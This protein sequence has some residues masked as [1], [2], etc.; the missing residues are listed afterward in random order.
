MGWVGGWIYKF[1]I[2]GEARTEDRDLVV[3]R[4]W[5]TFNLTGLDKIK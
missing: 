2:L 3:V 1:G 4:I 5:K